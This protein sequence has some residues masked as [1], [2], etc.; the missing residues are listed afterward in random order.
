MTSMTQ[1]NKVIKSL[2]SLPLLVGLALSQTGCG[3]LAGEKGIFRDRSNDY[4][5]ADNIPPLVLPE[6]KKAP[7]SMGELYPIPP[8]TAT[9]FGYDPSA[10]YEVPRPLPLAANSQQE[11]VKIQRV[12]GESWILINAAPG[13]LWPRIRN[14][15]NVNGLNA[16]YANINKGIIE[17][18]WLQF[19]TDPDLQHVYRLQIDQGVQPETSEIHVL[20][21]SIPVTEALPSEIKWPSKSINPEREKWLMD[22]L[23]ATL[24]NDQTEGGT[25]LLAQNIG[26]SVK[27]NLGMWRTETALYIHLDRTRSLATLGYAAK[28]D[29]FVTFESDQDAGLIYVGYK[30][31]DDMKPGW[32]KRVLHLPHNPKLPSTDYTLAQLKTLLPQGEALD[33]AAMSKRNKE[34]E[35]PDAEGYLLIVTGSDNNYVVRIRD[36]YGKRLQPREA[37]QLLTILRKN[38]I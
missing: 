13:E 4:L 7:A 20:H 23:A 3:W 30:D 15:L 1:S 32:F 6:G 21:Y 17:T 11:N 19:K 28:K 33:N 5:K 34:K 2:C 38:L 12:G 27:A 25:S 18:E 14:F 36:P 37:R 9:D 24:A 26:G 10:E 22:E 35:L 29:G 31:P 16:T 8:V